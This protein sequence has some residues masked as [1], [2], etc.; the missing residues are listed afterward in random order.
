MSK[1]LDSNAYRTAVGKDRISISEFGTFAAPD[2]CESIFRR[3]FSYFRAPDLTDNAN[4]NVTRFGGG[5]YALTE[6]PVELECHPRT[7]GVIGRF[8][9]R[10]LLGLKGIGTTTAHPH[11]EKSDGEVHM[12]NF[13]SS[14]GPKCFYNIYTL[15]CPSFKSIDKMST[16]IPSSPSSVRGDLLCQVLTDRPGYIHSFALT[17]NYVVLVEYPY[18]TSVMR[19]LL[20]TINARSYIENF[21]WNQDKPARFFVIDRRLRRHTHTFYAPAFFSFHHVNAFE[22]EG[23]VNIDLVAFQVCRALHYYKMLA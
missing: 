22:E 1:F 4:V 10:D 6:T 21:T 3:F 23:F 9:P 19:L 11:F 20:A 5:L 12:T 7:L 14:F 13:I 8:D 15:T 16:E 17:A 18:T 2:P